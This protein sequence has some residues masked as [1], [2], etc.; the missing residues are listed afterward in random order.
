VAR[1][2]LV[3]CDTQVKPGIPLEY[4][5]WIA[6]YAV[7]K[8]PDVIV[9][10]GDWA[11]MHSLSSYDKGKKSFEGREYKKDIEAANEALRLLMEPIKAE[12]D[13]LAKGRRKRWNPRLAVTL[14]NHEDRIDRLI[15]TQRELSGLVSTNDIEF[16]KWGFEVYPFKQVVEIDGVAYAH[17]FASGPRGEACSSAAQMLRIH[18]MSCVAGH[19]QGKEIAYG[20]YPT[21]RMI[22]TILS[23]SAY[24]HEEK[25]LGPQGNDHWRGIFVLNE[26]NNGELDEMPVSL[27]YLKKRYERRNP[28]RTV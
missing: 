5:K 18:H 20:K 16:A 25:Y 27:A 6:D 28:A 15:E 3:I 19:K 21:G 7:A 9:I 17:Y 26:V 13:R 24:V 14:G 8:K 4:I 12:I 22:T 23:G 10:I 11:D 2:H 1:K